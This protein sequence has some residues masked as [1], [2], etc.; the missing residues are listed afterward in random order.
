MFHYRVGIEPLVRF[1]N[2]PLFFLIYFFKH[3]IIVEFAEESDLK[4]ICNIS[5]YN[6]ENIGVP[7]Q[8]HFLWFRAANRKLAKLKQ[9]KKGKLHI[10]NSTKILSETEINE[11]LY[12]CSNVSKTWPFQMKF[13]YVV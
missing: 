7:T 11:A 6:E 3:Y 4:N 9:S 12:L 5:A 10:E 2:I 8:S 13:L 1:S